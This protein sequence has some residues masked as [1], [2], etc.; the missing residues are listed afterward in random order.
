MICLF[1]AKAMHFFT[2]S[3]HKFLL[4]IV[5]AWG[6]KLMCELAETQRGA[7]LPHGGLQPRTHQLVL[8]AKVLVPVWTKGKEH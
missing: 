2:L 7:P 3:L 1:H 8:Y 4:E 6:A 5:F